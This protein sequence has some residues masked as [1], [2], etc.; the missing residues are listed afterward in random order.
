MA[1]TALQVLP[2]QALKPKRERFIDEY[3][4]DFNATQAAI[5]AGYSPRSAQG[6]SSRLLSNAM[7]QAEL[8]K[9]RA[10]QSDATGQKA[11]RV[12]AE[13]ERIGYADLG[14]I[15]EADSEPGKLRLKPIANWPE[16]CRRAI[17]KLKIKNFPKKVSKDGIEIAPEHDIIE[18]GFWDKPGVLKLLGMAE[19]MFFAEQDPENPHPINAPAPQIFIIA[20]QRLEL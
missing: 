12:R 6:S 14:D 20:G 2:A 17:S 10:A 15:W 11:L 13:L 16:D 4:I 9:R 7:V 5:R 18:I 19:G 1:A 8:A 3:L